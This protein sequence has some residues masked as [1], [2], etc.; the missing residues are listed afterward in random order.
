MKTKRY[1]ALLICLLQSVIFSISYSQVYYVKENGTGD[2]SSWEDA[3]SGKQFTAICGSVPDG[4]TFHLAEGN[5]EPMR[6]YGYSG[7][8]LNS[9]VKIIGGYPV[10]AKTGDK[11]EKGKYSTI[12]ASSL[13][14]KSYLFRRSN[15]KDTLNIYLEGLVMLNVMNAIEG[16]PGSEIIV[17][18]CL[19]DNAPLVFNQSSRVEIRNSTIQNITAESEVQSSIVADS[20][21]SLYIMDTKFQAIEGNVFTWSSVVDSLT[22]ENVGIEAVLMQMA[23]IGS[24]SFYKV[25]SSVGMRCDGLKIDLTISESTFPSVVVRGVKYFMIT[26]SNI[27]GEGIDVASDSVVVDNI[28]ISNK[29]ATPCLR[30][31]LSDLLVKRSAFSGGTYGIYHQG[32]NVDI[33]DSYI[34]SNT[35]A[36]IANTNLTSVSHIILKNNCIGLN[37]SGEVSGNKVGVSVCANEFVATENVISGNVSDGL[38]FKDVDE[39]VVENN[40]IGTDRKYRNLGNGGCGINLCKSISDQAGSVAL[41]PSSF[42]NAN[43]IGFNG[44]DGV[45]VS[46]STQSDESYISHNFIGVAPDGTKIPNKGYGV[47]IKGGYNSNDPAYLIENHLGYNEAGDVS[48]GFPFKISQN[49]FHGN[50]SKSIDKTYATSFTN[51]DPIIK[52]V[53]IEG[54]N[55]IV[56]GVTAEHAIVDVELFGTTAAPQSA[57]VYLGKASLSTS[58]LGDFTFTVPIEKM[59]KDSLT[60]FVATAW[61]ESYQFTTEL[62][63]PYCLCDSTPENPSNVENLYQYFAPLHTREILSLT[64]Y[65]N[66]VK[67]GEECTV[68]ASLSSMKDVYCD[69]YDLNG[70][71]IMTKSAK[72]DLSD[73]SD[74]NYICKFRVPLSEASIVCIRTASEAVSF[75]VL[76]QGNK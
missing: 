15:D 35:E 45:I 34:Y 54:A 3:M 60:C 24:G 26:N 62:S 11:R 4:T 68:I 23:G 40:Y 59:N 27:E 53:S 70:G 5:Y 50:D 20:V 6:V 7:F 9:D 74:L 21:S 30:T 12:D 41:S 71:L 2:G 44:G 42:D 76:T 25:V 75:V 58:D 13:G 29:V 55:Y 65:P 37:Q 19:F 43:V 18:D 17:E 38:V 36:G 49:I 57:V 67:A 52:S 69:V 51:F 39:V 48:E 46:T 73:S 33:E 47:R 63:V 72:S 8:Y 16:D 22:M 56:K 32:G 28:Q 64:A 10:N 66:P 31:T 61:S 1:I 14:V